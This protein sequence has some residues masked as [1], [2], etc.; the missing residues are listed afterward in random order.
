MRSMLIRSG[1]LVIL[2]FFAAVASATEGTMVYGMFGP[3]ALGGSVTPQ[4][5]TRFDRGIVRAPTGE[6]MGPQRNVRPR[7]SWG[8]GTDSQ[9]MV[10]GSQRQQ[11]YQHDPQALRS[12]VPDVWPGV[13]V[14]AA[15][16]V[17]TPPAATPPAVV[18]FRPVPQPA[19]PPARPAD[20][21]FRAPR[22]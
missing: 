6:I 2:G 22:R 17:V 12:A 4:P 11:W 8:L 3:R 10:P 13:P 5:R 9:V 7:A 14:P 19:T 20:T 21:W 16:P 1:V 18:P 15:P